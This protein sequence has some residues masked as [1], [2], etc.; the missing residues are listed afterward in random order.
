MHSSGQWIVPRESIKSM[1]CSR[2]NFCFLLL[3]LLW[4]AVLHVQLATGTVD[5]DVDSLRDRTQ[6]TI[7]LSDNSTLVLLRDYVV[8]DAGRRPQ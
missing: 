7:S 6:V 2:T 4:P 8:D 3:V 1:S 5:F